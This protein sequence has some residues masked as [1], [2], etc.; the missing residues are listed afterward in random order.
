[1]SGETRQGKGGKEPR[2]AALVVRPLLRAPGLP[3]LPDPQRYS[4]KGF[5]CRQGHPASSSGSVP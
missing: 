2:G 3:H 1:M 5:S 4:C